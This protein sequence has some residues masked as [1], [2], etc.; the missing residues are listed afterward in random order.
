MSDDLP[1]QLLGGTKL[2]GQL[3]EGQPEINE[4]QSSGRH[5]FTTRS[6]KNTSVPLR[7]IQVLRVFILEDNILHISESGA[8]TLQQQV[9]RLDGNELR[10][11]LLFQAVFSP[12]AQRETQMQLQ[13]KRQKQD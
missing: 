2:E 11:S 3:K 8:D 12:G 13:E 6:C 1:L 4:N 10:L 9:E 7:A 5:S